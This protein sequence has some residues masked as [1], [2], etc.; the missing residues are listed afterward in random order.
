V[1]VDWSH[2]LRGH[3]GYIADQQ[4]FFEATLAVGISLVIFVSFWQG[5]LLP[6]DKGVQS[7]FP[8]QQLGWGV[9]VVKCCFSGLY[10]WSAGGRKLVE[11]C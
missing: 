9:E 5:S 4:K 3:R 6:Y 11:V 1:L 7:L 2:R 8:L 10:H